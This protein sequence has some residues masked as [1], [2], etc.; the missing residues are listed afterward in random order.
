MLHITMHRPRIVKFLVGIL[1][2]VA[3]AMLYRF[4]ISAGLHVGVHLR[5]VKVSGSGMQQSAGLPSPEELASQNY[6]GPVLGMSELTLAGCFGE[7]RR[8]HFHTGVDFRTNQREGFPVLAAADGYISRINVSGAGYGN[9]LY[10]THAN[11]YVT[12][13]AHLLTFRDDIQ[14]RLRAEQYRNESFAVDFQL[15]PYEI[16]VRKGDTI[17]LSGNTGGSGGPHLHFEIRDTFENV[18]NPLL[19]G[20]RVKDDL[21]PVV[22]MLKLY[23]M[24]AQRY[25]A[26]GYRTKTTLRNGVY[27]TSSSL[28]K[29]NARQVALSVHTYDLMNQ[30]DAHMGIYNLTLFDG[31]RMLYNAR[32]DKLTFPE[33]RYVFSHI[34]YPIFQKEGRK[35]YHKCYVEPGNRCG[36]YTDVI[37]A[38]AVDLSDG[39]PHNLYVEITDFNGNVSQIKL[40]L[41]YDPTAT[42]FKARPQANMTVFD[43]HALNEFANEKFRIQ[44]PAENVF[45]RMLLSY[46]YLPAKDTLALSGIHLFGTDDRHLYDWCKVW[47]KP[48][49]VPATLSDKAVLVVNDNCT[50]GNYEGGWL[51][52]RTREL[53][54]FQVRLDTTP[55]KIITPANLAGKNL[56][57]YKK[58]TFSV[59]DNLSGIADFDV[60]LDG[61]W[62]VA[63][64]DAKTH[65]IM[66]YPESALSSGRHVLKLVVSD[67]RKNKSSAEFVFYY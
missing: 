22:G 34:D 52:A 45:D 7:P 47:V 37:N 53:G 8:S 26:E 42:I 4:L 24:D 9:A 58:I 13:Y 46:S 56:R 41:Q 33:K 30:T 17:A 50:G 11:G 67:E 14:Q 25:T 27:V 2:L 61:T 21:K 62:V 60:Y 16:T 1:L 32:F 48:D 36:I 43:V 18:Y 6:F 39:K 38:G 54:A 31:D 51:A 64:Y 3:G 12:V 66:Y 40:S 29:C 55:P 49:R 20:Y 57:N 19:F 35:S 59:T 65:R 44:V 63:D 23:A 10:I 28:I 5:G 15:V